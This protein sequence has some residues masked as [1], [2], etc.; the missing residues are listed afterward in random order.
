MGLQ[1]LSEHC[2][3]PCRYYMFSRYYVSVLI[4]SIPD[5]LLYYFRTYDVHYKF[6]IVDIHTAKARPA[7]DHEITITL[8]QQIVHWTLHCV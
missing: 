3:R 5:Y 4:G 7:N 2:L 8:I 1:I 6:S